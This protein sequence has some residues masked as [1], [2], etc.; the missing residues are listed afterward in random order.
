M[1]PALKIYNDSKIYNAMR[2]VSIFTVISNQE[3]CSFPSLQDS[4]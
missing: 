1:L 3:G 4:A 2:N